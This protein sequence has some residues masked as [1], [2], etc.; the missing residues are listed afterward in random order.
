MCSETTHKFILDAAAS[1]RRM[2][3]KKNQPNTVYLD[4]R[5]D[6]KLNEDHLAFEK[7]RGGKGV[8]WNPKNL[9]V[10]GDFRD[11]PYDDNQFKLIVWDPPHLAYLGETS[12]YKKK[13]GKLN[14]ET[15]PHDIKTGAKELWRVLD[16][17]GV[18]IFKWNNHDIPHK[19]V[20]RLFPVTPLFG[21]ITA[22]KPNHGTYTKW[23]CFLKI[24]EVEL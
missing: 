21:Q 1:H 20:L 23:F 2:W 15:W 8:A 10:K 3:F 6:K 13:F 12:I 18:L 14:A 19:S 17:Y 24:P 5:D 9:T 16:D 4:I 7:Q 11:L 22:G